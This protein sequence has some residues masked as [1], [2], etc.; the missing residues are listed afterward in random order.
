MVFSKITRLTDASRVEF[1]VGVLTL[2][3]HLVSPFAVVAVLAH[4][5]GV[6]DPVD[7]WALRDLVSVLHF[8]FRNF[9]LLLGGLA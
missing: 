6:V 1:A 3:R 2:G 4:A 7:V 9:F 5:R 8:L